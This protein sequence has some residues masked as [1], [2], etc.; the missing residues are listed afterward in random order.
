MRLLLV[1]PNLGVRVDGPYVDEGRMEPLQLGLLAAMAPPG[2][3]VTLADD[4][5]EPVPFDEPFDLVALTVETFTARRAYEI[6]DAFRARGVPVVLGGFHPTLAPAEAAAHADALVTGDAESAWPGLLRDAAAGALRPRYEGVPGVP[7]PGGLRPRR[8][9]FRGRGYLPI[10]LLQFGRGCRNACSYCAITRFFGATHRG[11]PVGDVV[12][13]IEAQERRLLFFVDDHIAADR[14]AALALFRALVPLRVRWVSQVGVEAADDPELLDAMAA[15]G[16][17]GNVVGFETL[18]PR[19]LAE[20]GKAT[21]LRGFDRYG[22]AVARFKA[23]GLLTWAAFLLGHDHETP[24]SLRETL[25]FAR[26]HRFTFAAFNVL[27]PYPATPLHGRLA[28]AGRL[29]YGGRW[30]TH[31]DYRFN[32]AAFRPA[33]MA[34]DELTALAF[35]L[36]AAWNRPGAMLHRFLDPAT[37]LRSPYR[38]AAF[39][40]YN[41]LFRRETLRKQDL[42]FGY[43]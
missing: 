17:L 19:G 38:A 8:D 35:E 6:A 1:R 36:R 23:R 7:Q 13:E 22:R 5:C 27:T 34:P 4:R 24:G 30:W 39:W 2:V 25:A 37:H 9:L 28:A 33:R 41:P 42:R 14:D 10:T 11:R 21:N 40:A 29:L 31:P 16:C 3:E 20:W 26:A 43:R 15:S 18:D 32:H 12:A